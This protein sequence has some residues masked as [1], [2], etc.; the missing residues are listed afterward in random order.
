MK[1][2]LHHPLL[3]IINTFKL[4]LPGIYHT[5]SLCSGLRIRVNQHIRAG[6]PKVLKIVTNPKRTPVL[7]RCQ[8]GADS[9]GTMVALYRIVVQ[10][11]TKESAITEMKEGGFGFHGIWDNLIKWIEA[12]NIKEIRDK[13]GIKG[14]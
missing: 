7:V 5:G 9:T 8:H 4:K 3:S 12:L 11:W 6:W 10:G 1:Q 2:I 14:K 13:T